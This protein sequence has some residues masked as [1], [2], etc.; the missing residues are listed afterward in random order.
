MKNVF[1]AIIVAVVCASAHAAQPVFPD[2]KPN[3]DYKNT[4][5]T[6]VISSSAV[7]TI[8]AVSGFREIVMGDPSIT[9]KVFYRIDGSTVNIP[10][11]GWW[12]D[13]S[14]GGDIEYNGAIY[15]QL[16][17]SATA[18]TLRRVTSRNR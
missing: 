8:A 7:T 15:L 11:V 5:D 2:S 18:V 13:P 9:T 12:F 3:S 17:P 4:Q 6:V 1:A 16:A 10:T 14:V